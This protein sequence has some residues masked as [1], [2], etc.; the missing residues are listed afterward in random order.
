MTF[1][2]AKT[3]IFI[4]F[5][6][7]NAEN[8]FFSF[9]SQYDG[10]I[11]P[12]WKKKNVK[13]GL[14]YEDAVVVGKDFMV[15]GAG[16]EGTKGLTGFFSHHQC[17]SIALELETSSP[18]SVQKVIKNVTKVSREAVSQLDLSGIKPEM[19]DVATTLV[20]MKLNENKLFTG[21]VGNSGFSIY[22]YNPDSKIIELV[23]RSSEQMCGE[24]TPCKVTPTTIDPPVENSLD[25]EEGDIVMAYSDGVSNV[26]PSSFMTAATNFLV[27]KMIQ[28]SKV[29]SMGRFDYDYDLGDFVEGYVQNLSELSIKLKNQLGEE[30]YHFFI[31]DQSKFKDKKAKPFNSS[32]SSTLK[33][34]QQ[35]DQRYFDHLKEVYFPQFPNP[36]TQNLNLNFLTDRLSEEDTAFFKDL[37]QFLKKHQNSS[38][39]N[40][41]VQAKKQP[42]DKKNISKP[43]IHHLQ[44]KNSSSKFIKEGNIEQDS[45]AKKND[46]MSVK[47][48]DN[49]N[50][51]LP[52]QG[53]SKEEIDMSLKKIFRYEICNLLD[54]TAERKSFTLIAKSKSFKDLALHN[55]KQYDIFNYKPIDCFRN[56][57]I[58]KTA[59]HHPNTTK[60]NCKDILDLIYPIH[61]IEDNYHSFH[62]CVLKAIPELPDDITPKQIADS[63]NSRYFARNIA[64]AVKYV[65]NDPRVIAS[66]LFFKSFTEKGKNDVIF[67][68]EKLR[69]NRDNWRVKDDDVSIAAAAIKVKSIFDQSNPDGQINTSFKSDLKLHSS[70]LKIMFNYITDPKYPNF[71]I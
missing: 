29:H 14:F 16:V 26:L 12:K 25:I 47:D 63:F 8:L 64:L 55:V 17:T 2:P 9:R 7:L 27:A 34:T 58:E 37:I 22:R 32:L 20:Y 18:E 43:S 6:G 38:R 11:Y 40:S 68:E 13:A 39:K 61:P 66:N 57:M 15:L 53:N 36:K 51:S 24:D 19:S 1:S 35:I 10:Y 4:F 48:T 54:P 31:F 59:T 46:D 52:Q 30:L 3:L 70:V 65:V 28:K 21:V 67:T 60:W 41:Q 56:K 23:K 45:F 49:K 5:F 50:Q 69:K 42:Y 71:I 62:E 33:N 44:S